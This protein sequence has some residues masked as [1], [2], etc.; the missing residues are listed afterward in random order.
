MR[1]SWTVLL[2]HIALLA[3][4]AF[5]LVYPLSI[6]KP[7]KSQDP[8]ALA[9]ALLVF[10]IAPLTTFT[11]AAAALVVCVWGWHRMRNVARTFAVL[12]VVVSA[13]IAVLS[14]I[15][16][17]ERMFHPYGKPQFE[18]AQKAAIDK[19]D[20]LVT[21]AM[22]GE[23]HAYPIRTMGYHHVVNDVVGGVPIAATY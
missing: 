15:N 18:T 1:R 20:M 4:G 14:R 8:V 22:R 10:R 2:V 17:F 11:L 9:R 16:V 5:L 7:F 19:D 12:M 3:F 6:I 13:G 21:V 23:S